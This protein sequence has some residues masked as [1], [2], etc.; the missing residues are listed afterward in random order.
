MAQLT[1]SST[2]FTIANNNTIAISIDP[3]KSDNHF[4]ITPINGLIHNHKERMKM[5][6]EDFIIG[7]H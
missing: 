1:A 5:M 4:G 2:K 7:K 3:T 6:I